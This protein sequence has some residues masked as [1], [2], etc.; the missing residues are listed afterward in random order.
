MIHKKPN[1][2]IINQ[3]CPFYQSWGIA[4]TFVTKQQD[5]EKQKS[6]FLLSNGGTL[7]IQ[8]PAL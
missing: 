5:W 3:V 4:N 1:Q 2:L 6:P 8:S 7:K